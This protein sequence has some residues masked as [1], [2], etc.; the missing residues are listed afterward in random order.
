[1]TAANNPPNRGNPSETQRTGAAGATGAGSQAQGQQQG[2]QGQ[3]ERDERSRSMS[4]P[5]ASQ[6]RQGGEE[7]TRFLDAIEE[8]VNKLRTAMGSERSGGSDDQQGRQ[9]RA[10]REPGSNEDRGESSL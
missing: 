10:T 5:G 4:A 8:N 6:G 9:G 3:N 1:M 2:K 7:T